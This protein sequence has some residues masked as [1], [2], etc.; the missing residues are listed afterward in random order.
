MRGGTVLP[1]GLAVLGAWA[2][3]GC[4]YVPARESP[5]T[6]GQPN[7]NSLLGETDSDKPLRPG[8]VGR[9]RVRAL[10]GEPERVSP[11]GTAEAYLFEMRA[12]SIVAPLCFSAQPAMRYVAVRVEYDQSGVLRDFQFERGKPSGY[13]FMGQL[14]TERP[15][16]LLNSVAPV[17]RPARPPASAPGAGVP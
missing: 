12:G 5:A 8:A 17:T 4:F 9:S 7:P 14:V 13:S 10:L 3:L 2:L 15:S 11:N 6:A 16:R 1:V